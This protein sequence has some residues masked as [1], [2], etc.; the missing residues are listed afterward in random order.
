[1]KFNEKLLPAL[2]ICCLIIFAVPGDAQ[3]RR[4]KKKSS[5]FLDLTISGQVITSP[6]EYLVIVPEKALE[7]KR[8]Y[9]QLMLI[10]AW[11]IK[12]KAGGWDLILP[13][14]KTATV[15]VDLI[16]QD[17][18]IHQLTSPSALLSGSL[19]VDARMFSATD[20]PKDRIYKAVRIRSSEALTISKIVWRCY[21]IGSYQ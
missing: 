10:F 20:L 4:S 15:E 12:M 14:G 11:H 9:Q 2:F 16:D 19:D 17:G 21:G 5:R 3:S 6:G 7:P 13:D 8:D 18:K 1:M